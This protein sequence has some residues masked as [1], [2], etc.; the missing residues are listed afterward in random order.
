MRE[1]R[2]S[3]GRRSEATA[4]AWHAD[5]EA[6]QGKPRNRTRPKPKHLQFLAYSTFDLMNTATIRAFHQTGETY[7]IVSQAEDRE[8][9]EVEPVFRAMTASLTQ[10]L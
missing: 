10:Q 6:L 2:T 4:S 1:I 3:G 9:P 5:I 7:L 8:L